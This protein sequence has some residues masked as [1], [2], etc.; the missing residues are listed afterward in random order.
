[1][2]NGTSQ[3]LFIVVAIVIFGIFI[4]LS[5]TVFGSEMK[6]SLLDL[7]GISTEQT[8]KDLSKT[9]D[10]NDADDFIFNSDSGTITGYVGTSKTVIVPME[11][12]DIEVKEISE[13]A[14][15][16]KGLTKIVVPKNIDT[17]GNSFSVNNDLDTL[18][19]PKTFEKTAKEKGIINST[20][21]SGTFF[22]EGSVVKYSDYSTESN[23]IDAATEVEIADESLEFAIKEALNLDSKTPIT[24][25]EI[26]KLQS[27]TLESGNVKSLD[28]LE[29]AKNLTVLDIS[30]NNL[31]SVEPIK[32][33]N[34]I[35]YLDLRENE[36]EDFGPLTGKVYDTLLVDGNPISNFEPLLS[37]PSIANKKVLIES[38]TL[39]IHLKSELSIPNDK[40]ITIKDLSQ[41]KE[42]TYISSSYS[43]VSSLVGLEYATNLE[44][45]TIVNA[46]SN[47][48]E[49]T[50]LSPISN[51]KK[52]KKLRL[53]L[54][55][56]N[57]GRLTNIEPLRNLT[58][59]EE[60]TILASDVSDISSLKTLK[61]LKSFTFRGSGQGSSLRD[62]SVLKEMTKLET[63]DLRSNVGI[64]SYEPLTEL[65][66]LKDVQV[67]NT[68]YSTWKQYKGTPAYNALHI[69]FESSYLK[70]V[71][72]SILN[73]PKTYTVR[74]S[75]L[76]GIK[77]INYNGGT[78]ADMS[79][80][81][82]IEYASDL[83]VIYLKNA[84]KGSNLTNLT[85]LSHL[86]ELK[87]LTL[88]LGG[89][90]TGYLSDI[91]PLSNL[92]NLEYLHI[93]H[94]RVSDTSSLD[95]LPNLKYFNL[96]Q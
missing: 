80:L 67:P 31:T 91:R 20:D 81:G 62:I 33:L 18:I 90:N 54:G 49:L 47:R 14:F 28:G 60:L 78:Y 42:L 21:V 85:P 2:T 22:K 34:N 66:N 36:I 5:N 89:T 82:G 8:S 13:R 72:T 25:G 53:T 52:L 71:F 58:G 23:D 16:N 94:S 93:L 29:Y 63:V 48:S 35:T 46:P 45:I 86:S 6:T 10:A 40:E 1:M 64:S 76:L 87:S 68:N 70:D 24:V 37:N 65:P 73:K 4:G 38:Q 32:K 61:N 7:F 44:S 59:L 30:D 56:T 15:S 41:M 79:K 96:R 26:R 51:L 55:G 17:I 84:T 50:N 12:E 3:G 92:K 77:E 74:P 43:D 57:T 27:L 95:N 11:I 9:L 19:L 88:I 69:N 75:D 39:R 83:E